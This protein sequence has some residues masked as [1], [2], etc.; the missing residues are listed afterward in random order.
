MV[1]LL[2]RVHKD[3]TDD[4]MICL[5]NHAE[6]MRCK[7]LSFNEFYWREGEEIFFF[8]MQINTQ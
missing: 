5:Q 7:D 4:V 8:L 2:I 3:E 1:V 6:I